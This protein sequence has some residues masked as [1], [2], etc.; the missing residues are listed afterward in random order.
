MQ[1]TTNSLSKDERGMT[2]VIVTLFVMIVLSLT[3][4]SFSQVARREQRQALD[5]QL[6]SQAFYAAESGIND[7]IR[8]M[9]NNP[10]DLE[11]NDCATSPVKS[12]LDTANTFQY[13]CVTFSKLMPSLEYGSIDTEKGQLVSLRTSNGPLTSIKIDWNGKD[14]GRTYS[15]C[16]N[17]SGVTNFPVSSAY[18]TNCDAGILRILL[19]PVPEAGNFDRGSLI[20]N[21]YTVY[22]RP[23]SNAVGGTTNY[24]Q[25]APAG[26]PNPNGQGSVIAANCPANG[27]CTATING[28]LP[29]STYFMDLKSIYL[30]NTVSITG[31]A[32]TS[33]FTDAQAKIDSTGKANDVLRRLQVRVPIFSSPITNQYVVE[34]MNGICKRLSVYPGSAENN[35]CGGVL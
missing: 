8:W 32:G 35:D 29:G 17:S 13:T 7:A 10:D 16:T 9:Q 20:N 28:L 1:K 27:R 30:T 34:V 18:S 19:M 4:I 2:A 33:I 12:S 21:S 22:L 5:R 24:V 14:K 11:A 25:Y 6:S 26:V 3:V 15:G 23:V 31:N